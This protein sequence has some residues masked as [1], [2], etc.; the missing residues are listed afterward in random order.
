MEIKKLLITCGHK[1]Y[2]FQCNFQAQFPLAWSVS[3]D[4][5][6]AT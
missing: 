4:R 3:G 1:T 2:R 6:A 5:F